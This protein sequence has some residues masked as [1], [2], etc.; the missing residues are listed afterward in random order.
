[1]K[2]ASCAKGAGTTESFLTLIV[3]PP[4]EN[5][6]SS[7]K[8]VASCLAPHWVVPLLEEQPGDGRH[9]E[10]IQTV[11]IINHQLLVTVARSLED[12]IWRKAF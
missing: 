8:T 5:S 3:E 1:M 9:V 12:F 4:G 2:E 10:I 11:T 6:E 7:Q